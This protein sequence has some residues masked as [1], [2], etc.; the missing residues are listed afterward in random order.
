MYTYK[1][2]KEKN[3]QNERKKAK[4][5]IIE[6]LLLTR[7]RQRHPKTGPE[8]RRGEERQGSKNGEGGGR[9]KKRGDR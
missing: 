5:K 6:I 9:E 7:L 8:G 1:K 4:K 2:K 3:K